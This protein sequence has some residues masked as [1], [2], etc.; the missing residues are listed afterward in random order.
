[1]RRIT[2][3][4]RAASTVF[5]VMRTT[6]EPAGA[7]AATC[8]AVARASSVSVLVIDCTR[9]G[10]VPPMTLSATRTGR[11]MRRGDME[12]KLLDGEA[13]DGDLGVRLEVE[14]VIVV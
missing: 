9:M 6:S 11:E 5:T 10:A 8:S 12:G 13:R 3:T 1:M 4:W 14:F 2:G 7:R